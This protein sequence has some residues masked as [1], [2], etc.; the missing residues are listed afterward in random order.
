[1]WIYKGKLCGRI[2]KAYQVW[3]K[4]NIDNIFKSYS[5][6]CDLEDL[7]N[8]LNYFERLWKKLFVMIQQLGPPTFFATFTFAERLWDPLIKTLHTLHASKLN[9]PNKIKDFQSNHIV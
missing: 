6:Y 4:L 9:L 3:V 2:S 8:S 1:M 7:H 5:S